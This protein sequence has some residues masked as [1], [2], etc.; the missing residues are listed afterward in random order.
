VKYFFD[1]EIHPL[2][3]VFEKHFGIFI[4]HGN[5]ENSND[6]REFFKINQIN[7][8]MEISG[9]CPEKREKPPE[10]SLNLQKFNPVGSSF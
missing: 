8:L 7:G 1:I 2:D 3:G 4:I 6:R 9:R 5:P 10:S